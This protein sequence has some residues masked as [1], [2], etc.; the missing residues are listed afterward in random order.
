MFDSPS[1]LSTVRVSEKA[2]TDAWRSP[3]RTAAR[4][5]TYDYAGAA[6]VSPSLNR[7]T[8]RTRLAACSCIDWAAADASSTS[9]AFCCVT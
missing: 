3:F 2:V 7:L 4:R 1:P 5:P 9:A 8:D 6:I